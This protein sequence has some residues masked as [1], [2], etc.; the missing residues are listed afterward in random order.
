Y[1]DLTEGVHTFAVKA[2]DAAGN[3]QATNPVPVQVTAYDTELNGTPQPLIAVRDAEFDFSSPSNAATFEC[4][5]DGAPFT[6]CTSPHVYFDLPDGEHSFQVRAKGPGQL[7]DTTPESF[8][9]TVDTTPPTTSFTL[10][11][12]PILTTRD[13]SLAFVA[14]EAVT[15]VCTVDGVDF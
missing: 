13:A 8:T 15:F 10:A 4:S 1:S 2:T 14:N 9:F 7:V 5:L 12:P 11:P 3:A 6:T